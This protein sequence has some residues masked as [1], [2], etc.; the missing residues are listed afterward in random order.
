M[1]FFAVPRLHESF[2]SSDSRKFSAWLQ[3]QVKDLKNRAVE[4]QIQFIL[5]V[6]VDENRLWAG[7]QDMGEA[8]LAA[9]KSKGLSLSGINRLSEVVFAHDHRISAG[10]AKIRFYPRGYSDQAVIYVQT[11]GN[12][13]IS[14]E[15]SPFLP[16]INI[17]GSHG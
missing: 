16:D 8:A 7:R 4:N 6:D 15:I 3:L 14:Y 17:G 1:L 9:A 5:F 11:R 2:F 12:Q 13:R 10:T